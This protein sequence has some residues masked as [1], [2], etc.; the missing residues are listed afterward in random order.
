MLNC[1]VRNVW[2]QVLLDNSIGKEMIT[3]NTPVISDVMV[4]IQMLELD[5]SNSADIVYGNPSEFLLV[6]LTVAYA[7]LASFPLK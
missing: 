6:P 4:A 5:H 3:C 1:S 2:R 7:S